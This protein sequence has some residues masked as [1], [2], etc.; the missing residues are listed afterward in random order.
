MD[1]R[2]QQQALPG[3]KSGIDTSSVVDGDDERE[4]EQTPQARVVREIYT[5]DRSPGEAEPDDQPS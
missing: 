5:A 3:E 1:E 2:D 4:R